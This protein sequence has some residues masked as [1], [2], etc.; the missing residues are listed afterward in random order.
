MATVHHSRSGNRRPTLE[1]VARLAGVGRGTVS[2]VVNGSPRVSARTRGL[3]EEAIAELGYVPNRAARALA[4]GTTDAVALV[5]P[6]AETRFFA[7]PYFPGILRGVSAEL[8]AR[9]TQ[10]LLTLIRDERERERFAQYAASHRVDGALLVSMHGDDPLPELLAEHGLPVVLNG[11]RSA[12]ESLPHVDT[13]N[14][15]GARSAVEHLLRTGRG[16]VATIGGPADMFVARCR[17]AGYRE[18]LRAAGRE[19]DERLVLSGDFTE[20]GGYRAMRRLLEV[21]PRLDAVFCASDVMAAGARLA[22][23]ESG[24]RVPEQVALVGFD[25]SAIARHMDPPL[26]SVRQPIE[27]MGREMVRV[28]WELRDAQAALSAGDVPVA[29]PTGADSP[30]RVLPTELVRRSS[31]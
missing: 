30:R 8:A 13:D 11:R 9:D 27:E 4:A 21:E 16:T 19:V 12:T 28:L 23:R 3:V 24:R 5:V 6:E 10:L 25:D 15:A 17:A 26:T 29:G 31:S 14:T 7:E 1:E 22:L 20:E 18:A 2:R